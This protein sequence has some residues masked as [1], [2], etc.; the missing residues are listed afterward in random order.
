MDAG[1]AQADGIVLAFAFGGIWATL[2]I[3]LA[4]TLK[5]LPAEPDGSV[6]PDEHESAEAGAGR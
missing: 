1:A 2:A 6:A 5:R 3:I 4:F